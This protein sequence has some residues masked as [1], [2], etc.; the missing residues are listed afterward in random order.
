MTS[1]KTSTTTGTDGAKEYLIV[2][3]GWNEYVLPAE[4]AMTFFKACIGEE[5]YKVDT[6]YE[7][8]QS[9]FILQ[10]LEPSETPGLRTITPVQMFAGLEM[11]KVA[12]ERK[13]KKESS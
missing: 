6:F 13:R 11:A 7:D 3:I 4:A 12:D 2:K 1:K 10:R 8:G 9:H 5:M